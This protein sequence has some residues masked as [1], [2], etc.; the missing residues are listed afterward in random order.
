YN[1]EIKSIVFPSGYYYDSEWVSVGAIKHS[2]PLAKPIISVDENYVL[3]F[4][5][6]DNAYNY[7]VLVNYISIYPD[8]VSFNSKGYDLSSYLTSAQYYTIM[9]KA[10]ANPQDAYYTDSVYSTIQ[11]PKYIQLATINAATETNKN[12]I[13]VELKDG[14]YFID[15]PTQTHAANYDVK[16]HN[17]TTDREVKFNILSTPYDI[18]DY[19][20]ASGNYK[21]YVRAMANTDSGYLYLSS[22]ES[23]NP[24][25]LEKD[26][27]TLSTIKNIT[28]SEKVEGSNNLFLSWDKVDNAESYYLTISYA[29]TAMKNFQ[30]TL[31]E[32]LTVTTNKLNLGDYISLEGNYSIRIKAVAGEEYESSGFSDYAYNHTMTIDSDFKRNK[33]F[34]NGQTYSHYV[35]SYAQLENLINYYYLF[36]DI[37]YFETSLSSNYNLKIM[38]GVEIDVLMEECAEANYGFSNSSSALIEK[39]NAISTQA[40][41]NYSEGYYLENNQLSA[42]VEVAENETTYYVYNIKTGLNSDKTAL[43]SSSNE[44][45]FEEKQKTLANSLRRKDNYIFAIDMLEKIDVSNTEQLFMAVQY[46]RSPNFV[47]NST[48]ASTIYNNAKDILNTIINDDMT[49]YQKVVAIYDWLMTNVQYNMSFET[50]L[51]E[52]PNLNDYTDLTN[53]TLMGNVK[54]NYLEGVFYDSNNRLASS[55]GLA[56][57]FVLMCKIEGIDAIKVNGTKNGAKHYWNKVFIDGTPN[58]DI[59][60]KT[61]FTVD[62]ASSYIIDSLNSTNY[63]IESHKYFLVTD[64][65]IKSKLGVV[66]KYLPKDAVSN[67]T[68][69][70]YSN[71]IYSYSKSVAITTGGSVLNKTYSGSG[72]LQ[73]LTSYGTAEEYIK[74]IMYYLVV[75]CDGVYNC[76]VEVDM[77]LN[78]TSLI[79][80]ENNITTSYYS[81]V[82]QNLNA[83]FRIDAT[84]YD[85]TLLI[86]VRPI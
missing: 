47:G 65:F 60:Q 1:I 21:I 33:V 50:L 84:S 86:M 30:T 62:L 32:E 70:Y 44:K 76:V 85:S 52:K 26:K 48:V 12:G 51:Q 59:D 18:T 81:E 66:E 78:S 41:S 29:N 82:A 36:N 7:T 73:Y 4:E 13:N 38:L 16:I 5:E 9:V 24:F 56:K 55:N 61:W 11:V 15:F 71:S 17:T 72:T 42:P 67:T 54:Y 80:L 68:I 2:I 79:T 27:P 19:V 46:N 58:N 43:V 3:H 20:Q 53:S 28:I 40:I 45:L 69:N 49:D 39:L 23:S 35:T 77:A 63:Q 10:N 83:S 14:R 64:S 31:I 6:V 57:A 34:M 74:D 37:T 8:G 25:V 22:I 75:E